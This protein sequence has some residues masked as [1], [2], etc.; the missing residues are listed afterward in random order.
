MNYIL[1][2]DI[3]IRLRT[4]WEF[5]SDVAHLGLAEATAIG[6]RYPANSTLEGRLGPIK[7]E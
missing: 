2:W 6:D 5:R 7:G 4:Y 3:S 1:V